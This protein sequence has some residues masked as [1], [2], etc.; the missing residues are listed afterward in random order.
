MNISKLNIPVLSLFIIGFCFIESCSKDE[1]DAN[2]LYW[3]QTACADP[4]DISSNSSDK[5][6]LAAVKVYL[7]ENNIPVIKIT[8]KKELEGEFCEA[9][10]C[11]TGKRIFVYVQKEYTD[12]M[13][14]LGFK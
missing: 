3:D 4:W 12:D 1:I 5:E 9:C 7:N 13:K 2:V 6:Q 11:L 10:V 8:I 14:L